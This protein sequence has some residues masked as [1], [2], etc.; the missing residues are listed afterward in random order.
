MGVM[1]KVT[2]KAA[3]KLAGKKIETIIVSLEELAEYLEV[4]LQEAET[5]EMKKIAKVLKGSFWTTY[6][7]YDTNNGK[8]RITTAYALTARSSRLKNE[9]CVIDLEKG[10]VYTYRVF[11]F[12]GKLK[13]VIKNLLAKY[14][15]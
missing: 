2:D 7:T 6:K 10:K 3:S 9:V 14:A 4:V 8:Y 1:D 11:L 5:T 15:K 13:K 12:K